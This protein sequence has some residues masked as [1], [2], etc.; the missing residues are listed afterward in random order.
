MRDPTAKRTLRSNGARLP[1][2][3]RCK[4]TSVYTMQG[5]QRLHDAR[6]PAFTRCKATSVYTMQGYQR[7]HDARLPAVYTMQG[8]QRLHDARLPAFTRCKATSVYT[9]QGYQRLHD[10]WRSWVKT[11]RF[12][13]NKGEGLKKITFSTL[14]V[15]G[16]NFSVCNEMISFFM[17]NHESD[18]SN[19]LIV[20]KSFQ[21]TELYD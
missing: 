6:L 12:L 3:T 16:S 18:S 4:A 15:V 1:A 2:F 7:L 17:E 20:K 8:Y 19:R 11:L 13:C 10:A 9:M 5:Y 14:S 21:L